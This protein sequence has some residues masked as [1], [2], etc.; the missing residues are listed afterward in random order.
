MQ[1][2]LVWADYTRSPTL[3]KTPEFNLSTAY[4]FNCIPFLQ[5]HFNIHKNSLQYVELFFASSTKIIL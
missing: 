2:S 1:F 5:S 3:S 4:H